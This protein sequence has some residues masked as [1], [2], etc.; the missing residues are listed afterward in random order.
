MGLSEFPIGNIDA[1]G[2]SI[3]TEAE[4][5]MRILMIS[6]EAVPFA[7]T[8]G[9]AD[10]VPALAAALHAK[11]HDVRILMPRYYSI[12]RS[13][14]THLPA[15]LGVPMGDGEMWCGVYETTLPGTMVPI[16]FLDREDLYGR[17]KL[18]GPDG[19]SSW[20]DN[21]R[22]YAL[23]SA[24]A[25]QL[26]RSRHWIPDILHVHDWQGAPAAWMLSDREAQKDFASTRS[27]LTIHNLGYQGVFP[28]SDIAVFEPDFVSASSDGGFHDGNLNFLAAGL[29]HA[30]CITTVSPTYAHE[31]LQP[32][33][34]EGLGELLQL[35][36][37]DIS[38]I[39]NGMDYDEWNPSDDPALAPDNFDTDSLK[40]KSELKLRLQ[41]TMQLPLDPKKALFGIITRLTGQKGVDLLT[42]P[43]GP[44][45]RAFRE[46]R[47]QLAILGTGEARYEK[48][49]RNLAEKNPDSVSASIAF[50]GPVS[51]LIE[52]GSD[53]FL[54]PS[55]YEPCGLNQMYS[56]R[57]G[58]LPVVRRTGGL[59]DTV[60]DL[61]A[62]PRKGNGF[63]FDE[64]SGE[65][66]GECIDRAIEFY[67]KPGPMD[68]ARKRGMNLRFD[69]AA[70]ADSYLEV[71]R[72]A[73]QR[74]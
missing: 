15:P 61:N 48:A 52:G 5:T 66:L 74:N 68:T 32:E 33:Y 10:A 54:M 58:T 25:F 39:L 46:G 16:Y 21:A 43:E 44:A 1:P 7:K 11:G 45:V 47:A 28:A 42:D 2:V 22:R 60:I 26:A 37:R 12:D 51:R 56:L 19:S 55:R 69:W 72:K 4:A 64:A 59:A 14:L 34:S 6:S 27:V 57:Y 24:A 13:Y 41:K 38:G 65:A 3:Q 29:T 8:G 36:S 73:L 30:D 62:H 40:N 70:S 63:V 18:Y 20:P 35:R 31:I 50:S 49:F 9:L 23:L 67:R 53:F 17:E 71:F